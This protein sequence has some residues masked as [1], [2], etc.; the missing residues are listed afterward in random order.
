SHRDLSLRAKAD[1]YCSDCYLIAAYPNPLLSAAD[2]AWDEPIL[3]SLFP[4]MCATNRGL[5]NPKRK[6]CAARTSESTAAT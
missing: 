2:A 4:R 3:A 5:V 1:R 6:H